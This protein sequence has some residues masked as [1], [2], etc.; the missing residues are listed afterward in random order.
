ME[1]FSVS[2]NCLND[3]ICR[4]MMEDLERFKFL[5]QNIINELRIMV[6]NGSEI[7]K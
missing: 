3:S 6:D 5:L 2:G 7:I 1:Y 4:S